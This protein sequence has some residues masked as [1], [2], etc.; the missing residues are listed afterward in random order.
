M[1]DIP[2]LST[3]VCYLSL[4]VIVRL[5]LN[6]PSLSTEVCFLSLLVIV[7]LVCNI[8]SL[9]GKTHIKKSVFSGQTTKREGVKPPEPLRK[10]PFLS[11]S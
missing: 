6:I 5:V 8:Q 4:L 1:L 2:S 3:E 9:L 10:K 7:R 11:I